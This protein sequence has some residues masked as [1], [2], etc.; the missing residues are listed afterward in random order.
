MFHLE[1]TNSIGYHCRTLHSSVQ[2]SLDPKVCQSCANSDLAWQLISLFLCYKTTLC[3]NIFLH[4]LLGA[5]D[6]NSNLLLPDSIFLSV[7]C[8]IFLIQYTVSQEFYRQL[9]GQ[10][11]LFSGTM[12]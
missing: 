3:T 9:N 7:K 11:G 1:K 12:I 6:L 10:G 4:S 8:L 5:D 2:L